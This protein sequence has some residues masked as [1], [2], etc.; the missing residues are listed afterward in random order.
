[1]SHVWNLVRILRGWDH[2]AAGDT[3]CAVARDYLMERGIEANVL[4]VLVRLVNRAIQRWY[5]FDSQRSCW[6]EPPVRVLHRIRKAERRHR[7]IS[8][9]AWGLEYTVGTDAF[10]A[11]RRQQ[12]A[13]YPADDCPF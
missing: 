1:M 12:E 3:A 5:E 13:A 11:Y 10:W 9:L 2:S 7:R 8:R 6:E 4:P